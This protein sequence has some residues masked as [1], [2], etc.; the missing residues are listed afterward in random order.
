MTETTTSARIRTLLLSSLLALGCSDPGSGPADSGPAEGGETQTRQSGVSAPPASTSSESAAE[1][2]AT[3]T[4]AA[5]AQAVAEEP[6]AQQRKQRAQ[7][8]FGELIGPLTKASEAYS[9]NDELEESS[10]FGED[11][12][13]NQK[14]ID[15]LLDEA[16]RVLE[17]SEI[18]TT[19]DE[20]RRLEAEIVDLEARILSDREA[21]LSAPRESELGSIKKTYKTSKEDYEK[22]IAESEAAIAARRESIAGL[23]RR[24]VDELR[25]V[26]VEISLESARSLLSSVAGDDFIE[27][28]AVFENVRGVTIQ[29]QELTEQS[30]ESLEAAKRYY[31]SYL[32]LIRLMDRLQKDFVR[33]VHDEM[34]PR[35]E[36]YGKE[37]ER[38]IQQAQKNI[39][40]GGNAAIGEQ[41]IASNQLTIRATGIYIQYLREQ[42]RDVA[43]K[44]EHV[45]VD[46]ED[47]KNTYETVLL[48]SQVANLL[49]QGS[50][51]FAAL[52]ELAVPELRGFENAELRAEFQRLTQRLTR[53]D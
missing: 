1:A 3:Q 37:A 13:D 34:I 8:M 7:R 43:R 21:R 49:K 50:K 9:R 31:G 47:A 10:W 23:E 52:L 4:Q 17:S 26:G 27:M 5:G 39:A 38:L 29:L 2:V 16:V 19:R 24:F 45:Q 32:V 28:C 53:I 18:T 12:K 15:Q 11:Q 20:L 44:N 46:L 40:H 22:R 6:N 48:S 41:N 30:G 25:A 51:N 35:L 42:S 33:R 36:Q 14:R